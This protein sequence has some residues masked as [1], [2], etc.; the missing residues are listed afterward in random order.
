MVLSEKSAASQ[1][2]G[3]LENLCNPFFLSTTAVRTMNRK[4]YH[5][6]N[7]RNLIKE[8]ENLLKKKGR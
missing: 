5:L 1:Y 4:P 8:Y 3:Y 2:C 7:G 6:D